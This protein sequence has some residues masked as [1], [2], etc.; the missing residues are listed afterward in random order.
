M[1]KDIQNNTENDDPQASIIGIK[2][3]IKPDEKQEPEVAII[4]TG[5]THSLTMLQAY[6][7]YIN[8]LLEQVKE[9]TL[10][11]LRGTLLKQVKS[12]IITIEEANKKI[13][14]KA[15][16]LKTEVTDLKTLFIHQFRHSY[17]QH[18]RGKE[19]KLMDK[20]TLL[21]DTDMQT[22][23]NNPA[24]DKIPGRFQ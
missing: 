15:D 21:A 13:L 9:R 7:E 23:A 10:W 24:D 5:A 6:E 20:I 3:L 18:S 11:Y 14:E 17:Y 22:R 2:Y 12:Q 4:P 19:G 1:A 8:T 16:D